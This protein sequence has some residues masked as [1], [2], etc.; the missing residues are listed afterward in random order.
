MKDDLLEG[1]PRLRP[2][3]FAGLPAFARP[4]GY[5]FSG[6]GSVALHSN[7][8]TIFRHY[9]NVRIVP[10]LTYLRGRIVLTD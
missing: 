1:R 7:K 10:D 8:G 5:V 3:G 9:S 6:R 2:G 4:N